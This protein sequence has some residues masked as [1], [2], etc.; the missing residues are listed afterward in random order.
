MHVNHLKSFREHEVCALT[1]LAEEKELEGTSSV[2]HVEE[3]RV[4][5]K[6]TRGRL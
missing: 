6:K 4:I 1:V 5:K 3:W 2:L